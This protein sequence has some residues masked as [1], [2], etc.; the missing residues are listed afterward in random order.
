MLLRMGSS[1]CGLGPSGPILRIPPPSGSSS[2]HSD[3]HSGRCRGRAVGAR[4]RDDIFSGSRAGIGCAGAH[5]SND[6]AI[7]GAAPSRSRN[8]GE[9]EEAKQRLPSPAD[10]QHREKESRHGDAGGGD[11]ELLKRVVKCRSGRGRGVDNERRRRLC[12]HRDCRG[13]GNCAGGRINRHCW[14]DD[15]TRQRNA[16]NKASPRRYRNGRTCRYSGRRDADGRVGQR[17]TRCGSRRWCCNCVSSDRPVAEAE[18]AGLIHASHGHLLLTI[19]PSSERQIEINHDIVAEGCRGSAYTMHC[20]LTIA[21][22]SSRSSGDRRT[23]GS[24]GVVYKGNVSRAEIIAQL[25]CVCCVSI[26]A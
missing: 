4:H 12:S 7:Y 17:E 18:S 16:S 1:A 10:R 24:A 11:K 14:T 9:H 3:T 21:K 20:A 15:G 5:G 8:N 25:T 23:I 6:P 19:K 2:L 13:C 22:G 26:V